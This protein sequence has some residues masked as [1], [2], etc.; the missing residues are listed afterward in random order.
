VRRPPG[1]PGGRRGARRAVRLHHH[2]DADLTL[3]PALAHLRLRDFRSF[4]ALDWAPPAGRVLLV[5]DNGAGKTS[6]L[7]AVYL[8]ATTR[9]FRTAQ[10]GDC[11]RAG[12]EGFFVGAEV[13][14]APARRLAV[15]LAGGA[16]RRTLDDKRTPLAEHLAVLPALAWT[17]RDAELV[18]GAPAARRRFL[19][20][21]LV[22]LRPALLDALGRYERALAEKRALLARGGGELEPWN[23]LLA[24]HGAELAAGRARLAAELATQLA[25][26]AGESGLA[27]PPLALA[28]RPSPPAAV[29]GE[30][31]LHAE[32][33]RAGAAERRRGAPLVGPHRDD[34]AVD[35]AGAP[36]RQVASA[37]EQKLL[38]LLLTLAL[39]RRL[40]AAGR[41]PLL[42]VDDV[43]AE[44]DR[45]RLAGLLPLFDGFGQLFLTSSRPEVFPARAAL[46]RVAVAGAGALA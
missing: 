19:D 18:A 5:G 14:H 6:L 2:A 40:A 33:E 29:A 34:L 37:G 28:Y 42:L 15:A 24:R 25:A 17:Q 46:E 12:T 36:A 13:G 26:A 10:L 23:R 27:L 7:E 45:R 9:S 43:D 4:A 16:R 30:E 41:E 8:A 44:L 38:G 39:A 35:W 22:H 32:L 21:G 31:A 3:L 11:V 1:A 20:R